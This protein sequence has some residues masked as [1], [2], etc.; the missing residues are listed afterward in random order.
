[1]SIGMFALGSRSGA[2]PWIGGRDPRLR[3]IAACALTLVTLSLDTWT[4]LLVALLVGAGLAAAGGVRRPWGRLLA[5]EVFLL[6]LLVTL[7]LQVPGEL[8]LR[9]GPIAASREGLDQA[10]AIALRANAIVLALLGLVGTLEPVA[11]GH[12]LGRLGLPDKLVHLM[13]LTVRQAHVIESEYRRLRQAMRARAF[14]ARSDG[15]TWRSLGWLIG[16]LLVRAMERS[17][18]VL[19]AM[20][21]RGFHGRLYSL[22]T[23][24]WVVADSAWLV[25]LV[26]LLLCLLALD[27]PA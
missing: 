19:D 6:V 2:A 11:L 9:I 22:D 8:L 17:R 12:A 1:M 16:M 24:A 7:P 10:G 21:C 18:R 4:A 14:V 26:G 25:A 3:I 15:H 20:R 5:L 23:S 13:L 27:L